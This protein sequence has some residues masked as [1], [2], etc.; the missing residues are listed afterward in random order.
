VKQRHAPLPMRLPAVLAAC[1]ALCLT[2]CELTIDEPYSVRLVSPEPGNSVNLSPV[3]VWRIEDYTPGETYHVLVRTDFGNEPLDKY[4][5]DE[6]DTGWHSGQTQQA[7]IRLQET[8]YRYAKVW[9]A[10]RVWDSKGTEYV[11][12]QENW[13]FHVI[14]E[15]HSD[16]DD[17]DCTSCGG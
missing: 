1:A 12:R 3:L 13:W 4:Y 2:A 16:D 10:V 15:D 7:R 17:G 6:F 11:C 14:P 5:A 8:R 9:W